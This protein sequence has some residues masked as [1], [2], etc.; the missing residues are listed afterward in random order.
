MDNT[1]GLRK[2]KRIYRTIEMQIN[3][4]KDIDEN[5]KILPMYYSI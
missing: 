2:Y 5:P 3:I 4:Y 1:L